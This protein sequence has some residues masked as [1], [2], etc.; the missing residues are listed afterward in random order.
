MYLAPLRGITDRIFRNVFNDHFG[1]FDSAVAPFISTSQGKKIKGFSLKEF[2]PISGNK[3]TTIPQILSRDPED[4]LPVADSLL[5]LGYD[6]INWNIGCPFPMVTGKGKGSGILPYP[7]K[8]EQFLDKVIP[9]LKQ[10]LTIKLRLGMSYTD[11]ILQLI[12]LFNNYPIGEIIIHA[13]TA[14]QMYEGSVHLDSFE[15]CLAVSKHPI[16][17]NGD[18]DSLSVFNEFAAR[19]PD[20]GGWMIGRGVLKDPFLALEIRGNVPVEKSRKIVRIKLFHDDLFREYSAVLCGPSHL[21]DRMKEIWK[22]LS[23]SFNDSTKVRKNINKTV[24]LKQYQNVVD[25]IF[26]T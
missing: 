3:M 2:A 25:K 16:V 6:T 9:S 15:K 13:R 11:E 5:E 23:E 10:V 17:Y 20:V 12:P 4:F 14:D 21:M 22:Y 24:T 19:F 8:V 18:I 7:N 1:G 26:H